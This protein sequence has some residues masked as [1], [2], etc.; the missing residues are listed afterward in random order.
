M[1]LVSYWEDCKIGG[2]WAGGGFFC[3]AIL[4]HA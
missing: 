2:H 1:R 3:L 4:G